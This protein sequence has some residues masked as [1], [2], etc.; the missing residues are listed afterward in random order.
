MGTLGQP[1]EVW[2]S[3]APSV[4]ESLLLGESQVGAA[5]GCSGVHAIQ[6]LA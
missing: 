1:E 3:R 5:S 2:D 6:S 4:I